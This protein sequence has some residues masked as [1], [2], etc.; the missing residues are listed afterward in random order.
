TVAQCFLELRHHCP[1]LPTKLFGT[2]EKPC[3][4]SEYMEKYP[5]Y[6][7][8]LPRESCKPT[9][10]YQKQ[11]V[12]MEA[13]STT[14]RDYIPHEV[15]RIK[16]KPPDQY[17]KSNECMDLQSTYR[18][19]YNPY[20]ISRVAPCMPQEQK[21]S[22]DEKMNTVPT[23]KTDYVAWNQPKREMIKP[24]NNYHPP[25]EK[26]DHRTTNQDAFQYK[27]LVTTKNY[28][29][30]RPLHISKVPLDSMTNYKLNYVP[31]LIPK[32]FVHTQEPFQACNVP[33]DGL[34][35]HK[36]AYKGLAGEPAK[37]MKPDYVRPDA[38]NFMGT[39]EFKEKFLAW[40]VAT[41]I[42]RKP[43]VYTPPTEKM[44]LQT[45]AQTHYGDPHGCPATSYKPLARV[46]EHTEPFS[47]CST[48]KEDFQHWHSERPKPILP[49]C[50]ITLSS[51]PMDLMTSF[52]TH[53]TPHP[54]PSIKSFRPRLPVARPHLPFAETTTYGTSYTAKEVHICPASF[55]EPPGYVFEKVDEGGHRRFRPSSKMQSQ[56][57]SN[58]NNSNSTEL[59]ILL[60]SAL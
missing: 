49:H 11:P 12:P 20:S 53:Y 29:P 18:Q 30:G 6:P 32:R 21:Y 8:I 35:T 39:T 55:K 37:S 15:F 27:G 19:D 14:K 33:F 46:V 47:N 38:G 36:L 43:V 56:C 28:K 1:H 40:P 26:F 51:E 58:S 54:L 4:L 57:A 3:L 52:Q 5:L 44:D 13:L 23:Y 24:D 34:T 59:Y 16:Q 60:H 48:M 10:E 42:I 9:T 50:E 22:S 41:R 2:N 45:T 31:H 25:E 7:N 17:V